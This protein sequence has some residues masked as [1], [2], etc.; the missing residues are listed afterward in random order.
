MKGARSQ[1]SRDLQC[2]ISDDVTS[3]LARVVGLTDDQEIQLSIIVHGAS[4]ANLHL[5]RVIERIGGHYSRPENETIAVA[6]LLS[7]RVLMIRREISMLDLL[8]ATQRDVTKMR[9]AGIIF[10][11]VD[12]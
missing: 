12:P 10:P 2:K 7:A 9:Q 6:C 11:E 3:L 4:T 1:L 5:A 8:V